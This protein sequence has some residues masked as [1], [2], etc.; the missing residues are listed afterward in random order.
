MSGEANPIYVLARRTLLDA[1]EALGPHSKTVVLIGAQAIY[2]HTGDAD[3][4]TVPFTTDADFAIDPAELSDSPLIDEAMRAGGFIP[5]EGPGGWTSKDDVYVDLLVP[6][7]LAGKGTRAADLGIHG[8]LRAR[9][10]RGLEGALVDRAKMA[11]TALDSHDERTLMIWV[12]GPGALLVAKIHKIEERIDEARSVKKPRV[13][14]KDALDVL[15]LLRAIGAAEL[16]ACL[17]DLRASPLACAATNHAL[18]QIPP[19]FGSLSAPGVAMAV[20]AAGDDEEPETVAESMV[21]LAN[22]LIDACG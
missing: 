16:V 6:E 19:L 4:S 12:A 14:D 7:P 13:N 21:A 22:D 10:A 8:R 2:L 20:A 18:E 3:L 15:R 1:I 11:L 9:R 5:R 17:A